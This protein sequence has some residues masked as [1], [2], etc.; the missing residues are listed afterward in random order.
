LTKAGHVHT[1]FP[2]SGLYA[3]SAFTV[4]KGL[5]GV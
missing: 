1:H 2:A 3:S 5:W 4:Y